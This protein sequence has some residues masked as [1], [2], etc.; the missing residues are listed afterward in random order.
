MDDSDADS[1]PAWWEEAGRSPALETSRILTAT[2][3]MAA[4]LLAEGARGV[5]PREAAA[6]SHRRRNGRSRVAPAEPRGTDEDEDEDEDDEDLGS[7][8]LLDHIRQAR[9]RWMSGLGA[10]SDEDVSNGR[11]TVAPR[12]LSRAFQ[13]GLSG[14]GRGGPQPSHHS[15][16]SE[17]SVDLRWRSEVAA[18]HREA[19]AAT[20]RPV[21]ASSPTAPQPSGVQTTVLFAPRMTAWPP[22]TATAAP[23]PPPAAPSSSSSSSSS[24]AYAGGPTSMPAPPGM[25]DAATVAWATLQQSRGLGGEELS[26]AW[27][28]AVEAVL[29]GPRAELRR[30]LRRAARAEAEALDAGRRASEAEDRAEALRRRLDEVTGAAV[31]STDDVSRL[32]AALRREREGRQRDRQ[33]FSEALARAE[34][35]SDALERSAQSREDAARRSGE[36]A[37][38]ME[39]RALRRQLEGAFALLQR[40]EESA[41]KSRAQL[42][43]RKVID[44]TLEQ[45]QQQQQLAVTSAPPTVTRTVAGTVH[46]TRVVPHEEWPGRLD[47]LTASRAAKPRDTSVVVSGGAPRAAAAAEEW[48]R[49]AE[50]R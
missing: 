27:E 46:L 50:S 20:S 1:A 21:A 45:Q 35:K 24:A 10:P 29:R 28:R 5:V 23:P 4:S 34:A 44:R 43:A 14:G 13:R 19:A 26:R 15:P 3:A 12:H 9:E 6:A 2:Q 17:D 39:E 36:H 38:R 22:S 41:A 33:R 25:P 30:A 31:H 18:A 16:E 42:K 7:T 8:R 48:T 49:L 40:A 47:A 32:R 37:W 11:A